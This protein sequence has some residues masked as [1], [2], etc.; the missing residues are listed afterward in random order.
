MYCDD[1]PQ[2]TRMPNIFLRGTIGSENPINLY[3]ERGFFTDA[4]RF[5]RSEGERRPSLKELISAAMTLNQ[6]QLR[7]FRDWYWT[8]TES[9]SV[10]ISGKYIKCKLD[11]N[12]ELVPVESES[13]WNG[14][15]LQKRAYFDEGFKTGPVG[16][17]IY[18]DGVLCIHIGRGARGAQ[19]AGISLDGPEGKET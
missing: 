6:D 14:T 2:A 19:V 12:C 5:L 3:R 7:E 18:G 8:N 9:E 10:K 11:Q 15:P 16:I 1:M 4:D 17:N 13:E